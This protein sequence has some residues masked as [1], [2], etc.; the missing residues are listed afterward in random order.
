MISRAEL[1]NSAKMQ[2]KGHWGLAIL[3][4]LIY[5]IIVEG[6]G[7]ESGTATSWLNENIVITLNIIGLIFA[8]PIQLGFS[9]FILN[10]AIDNEKAKFTD[11]FSGF[12]VFIKSFV[13]NLIITIASVIGTFLFVIPG[14]IVMLMF[15]QSYY[16]L[17]ENPELSIM[18]C[19]KKSANMMKGFKWEL[20]ILELSFLGWAILCVFTLGIGFL[21]YT[22]YYYTTL[23]N[24]YLN[25]KSISNEDIL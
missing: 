15:S 24:F 22:P 21:W 25:L 14:I 1:K 9:R 5:T 11:L 20:F 23:G 18:D 8:G 3:T 12:N 17:A 13:I 10:L 6:T 4:C 16:I 19:L 2:L 7:V